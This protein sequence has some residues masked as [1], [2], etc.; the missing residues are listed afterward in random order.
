MRFIWGLAAALASVVLVHAPGAEAQYSDKKIKIG[1]LD[2]FSG[3][4]CL[5]NCMGP[6]VATQM[7][8]DEFGGK[9]NGMPIEIIHGDHQD[10]PDVGVRIAERWYDTEQV[11]AIVD[12]V[13]SAWPWR[14]RRWRDSAT[15]SCFTAR[16]AP[17]P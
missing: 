14:C 7:A 2:D 3:P 13:F 1:I 8:V 16:P 6:V 10:K 4:Y 5:D 9:I 15:R 12:V 11:D 17:M